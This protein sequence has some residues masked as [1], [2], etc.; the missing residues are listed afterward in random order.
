MPTDDRCLAL[1]I[2]PNNR[3]GRPHFWMSDF[4]VSQR[5]AAAFLANWKFGVDS[6]PRICHLYPTRA[7]RAQKGDDDTMPINTRIQ[8]LV[9]SAILALLSQ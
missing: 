6:K 4:C 2:R 9:I 5:S 1:A 8:T 7:H 3:N